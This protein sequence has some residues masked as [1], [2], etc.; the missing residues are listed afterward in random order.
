M[1]NYN[2]EIFKGKTKQE[3]RDY[4]HEKFRQVQGLSVVNI[5]K[6]IFIKINKDSRKKT[7]KPLMSNEKAIIVLDILHVIKNATYTNWGVQKTT[8]IT[9]YG[10]KG[11]L[12]FQ[13][14]CFIDGKCKNFRVSI[15]I[16]KTLNFQYSLEHNNVN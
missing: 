1:K 9:K 5:D 16:T 14:K 4:V 8:H 6:N 2:T 11:F 13:Y 3:V 12:N 15:L 10:A 7:A